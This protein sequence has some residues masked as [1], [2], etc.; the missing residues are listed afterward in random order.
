MLVELW[1]A[2][3]AVFAEALVSALARLD[4]QALNAKHVK[5]VF[6]ILFEKIF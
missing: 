2:E 1:L 3:T 5:L 6:N 4:I